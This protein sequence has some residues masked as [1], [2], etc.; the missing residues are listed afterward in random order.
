MVVYTGV[1]ETEDK[2]KAAFDKLVGFGFAADEMFVI[3]P[4][5]GAA[6]VKET[7]GSGRNEEFRGMANRMEGGGRQR[8]DAARCSASLVLCPAAR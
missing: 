3:T 1:F 8:K 5:E 6:K 7:L 4:A 2:A